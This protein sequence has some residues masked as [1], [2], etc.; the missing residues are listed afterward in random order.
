[1]TRMVHCKKYDE[2]LPGLPMPPYP[3]K[4]GQEIFETVSAKA[5][6]AWLA[7]Q[8]MLINEKH[9]NLAE[10]DDR[11]RIAS[12]DV[13]RGALEIRL[14]SERKLRVRFD[15]PNHP[16]STPNRTIFRRRLD[17]TLAPGDRVELLPID[18]WL[19][20]RVA[21]TVPDPGVAP[22]TVAWLWAACAALLVFLGLLS[23]ALGA[24]APTHGV[25]RAPRA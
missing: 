15:E 8:T 3:G 13:Y 22:S 23:V 11:G 17:R 12:R 18:G 9:L 10:P 24:G 14:R 25:H 20:E 5:W 16:V 4:K 2:E 6:Q 7:Q 21:W 1:M 19:E